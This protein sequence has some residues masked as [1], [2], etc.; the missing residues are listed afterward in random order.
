MISGKRTRCT[1]DFTTFTL[2]ILI[3]LVSGAIAFEDIS[4]TSSR[5]S[6]LINELKNSNKATPSFGEEDFIF[7]VPPLGNL[8]GRRSINDNYRSFKTIPFGVAPV[9]SL[10]WADPV[11]YPSWSSQSTPLNAT[12][13]GPMCPQ[14][15]LL[16]MGLCAE[17]MNEDC[18][19]LNVFSP[20]NLTQPLPVMVF[21]PGGHFDQ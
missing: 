18:L 4:H 10:R 3:I 20:N 13:F 21:I 19:S 11:P 12:T 5:L 15:C 6:S 1:T 2:C 16:P 9:G 14:A 7:N 8:R 17:T